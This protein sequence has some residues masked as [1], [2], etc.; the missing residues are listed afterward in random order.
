M[1]KAITHSELIKKSRATKLN[2]V[3]SLLWSESSKTIARGVHN[4]LNRMT[5]EKKLL[6][7]LVVE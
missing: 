4:M 2:E 6:Q 5:K 7:I 3:S 1:K